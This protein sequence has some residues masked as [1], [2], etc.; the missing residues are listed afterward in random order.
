MV[1]LSAISQT[2]Y[3]QT[4]FREISFL[5]RVSEGCAVLQLPPG[6][7]KGLTNFNNRC[8]GSCFKQINPR[9]EK[10]RCILSTPFGPRGVL[11]YDNGL[12]AFVKHLLNKAPYALHMFKQLR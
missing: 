3:V 10:K 11:Q 6:D 12:I 8:L 9:A 7:S 5:R 4:R 1:R 2:R